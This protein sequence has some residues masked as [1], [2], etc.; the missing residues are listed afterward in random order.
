MKNKFKIDGLWVPYQ[1]LTDK[2]LRDKEKIIYSLILF[3]SNNKGYC[4]IRNKYL[5]NLLNRSTKRI[6]SIINTLQDK[7]YI[8]IKPRNNKNERR[9]SSLITNGFQNYVGRQYPKGV[10]ESLYANI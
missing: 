1:I 5:E 8:H 2:K 10:L 6:S 7:R 4:S 3:F 9:L